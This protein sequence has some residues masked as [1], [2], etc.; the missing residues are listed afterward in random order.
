[1][2]SSSQA[3]RRPT[4][5][6]P[7][8]P[9][10]PAV[11]TASAA[12]PGRRPPLQLELFGRKEPAGAVLPV[13]P[14]P[15]RPV[16]LASPDAPRLELHRALNRLT[17][18]RLKALALTE[19][20]RT[21][22]SVRPGGDRTQLAVRLHHCFVGAPGEVLEAVATFLGSKKGSEPAR[23]A[24]RVIRQHFA[25]QTKP[26]ERRAP[27][28]AAHR[29]MGIAV[30]LR[31]MADD[32]NAR[33]FE[34]RLKVDITWGRGAAAP[35]TCRRRTRKTTLQLGSYSYEDKLI[36]IHRV[37][38]Q[39]KVP[40]YV[41]EAVVYHELL[42]AD[43]PPVIRTAGVTSTRP[44]SAAGSASSATS[45]RPSG[46]FGGASARAAQGAR[47][48]RAQDPARHEGVTGRASFLSACTPARRPASGRCGPGS[49]AGPTTRPG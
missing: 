30:D 5:R 9:A 16:M 12:S 32:L 27:R 38:D 29:T 23:Q 43:I 18:G 8:R 37:L 40:R 46:G 10:L 34:G 47:T 49:S 45:T 31:E 19:N 2:R 35:Q 7:G 15:G 24:L 33:Y 17:A 21:I 1:M 22:L 39:P 6:R 41:V 25:A 11:S 3:L 20:R 4:T 48:G 13:L 26:A 28:R 42:H 44:S 36:R 14:V